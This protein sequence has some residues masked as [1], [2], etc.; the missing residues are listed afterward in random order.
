MV[1]KYKFNFTQKLAELKKKEEESKS[2]GDSRFWK[3]SFDKT[4]MKGSAVI[5]FLPDRPSDDALPYINYFSHWFN[6]HDGSQTLVYND[7]CSTSIG[8][9]CLVC[10]KNRKY[11]KSPHPEDE[12][13]ARDRKRKSHFISNILVIK[14]PANPE[15]EGKVF[16]WD[17]GPQLA[18]Y[19]KRA[20]FGPD[21]EDEDF[22]PDKDYSDELW[23]PQDFFEGANFHIKSTKKKNSKYLTY[24]L[25]KWGEQSPI[26]EGL[27]DEEMEEKLDEIFEQVL[28]LD[29]WLDPKKFPSDKT[30]ANKL[31]C[32]LG[33]DAIVDDEDEI[34]DEDSDGDDG[35]DEGDEIEDPEMVDDG[36]DEDEEDEEDEEEEEEEEEEPEPPKK[37]KAKKTKA[38]KT[39]AK[40]TKAK[41]EVIS[42]EDYIDSLM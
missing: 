3:F 21:K 10:T 18:S 1:S 37:T 36:D 16:L 39:K 9:Q 12:K 8:K 24:L 41:V 20:M 5:R 22:D 4:T 17:Y 25:S 6:Y 30:V 28:K 32:I 23:Y 27:D 31:A 40:K 14:D 15:N 38:K 26:F 33:D 7:N 29:E 19:Y 42:D 11:W 13:I 35:D 34:E 2:F